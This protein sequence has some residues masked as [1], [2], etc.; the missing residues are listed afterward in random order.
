MTDKV[1]THTQKICFALII[2]LSALFIWLLPAGLCTATPEE[3]RFTDI[4][5]TVI[6]T[7][8]AQQ[9]QE[10]LSELITKSDPCAPESNNPQCQDIYTAIELLQSALSEE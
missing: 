9:I 4:A 1:K 2:C 3:N 6:A 7:Q 5:Q 10:L 8:D